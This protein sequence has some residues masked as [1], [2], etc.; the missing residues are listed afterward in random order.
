M[1]VDIN[2]IQNKIA[3]LRTL[4]KRELNKICDSQK[5]RAGADNVYV[6]R[7]WYFESLRFLTEQVDARASICTLPLTFSALPSTSAA[8][9]YS[10]PPEMQFKDTEDILLAQVMISGSWW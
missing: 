1:A 8:P 3:N 6:P 5:S 9:G 2:Y 4:Y 10:M 7:L